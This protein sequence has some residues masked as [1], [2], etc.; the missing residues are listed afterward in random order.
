[1]PISEC[2]GGIEE[3]NHLRLVETK[4]VPA[5]PTNRVLNEIKGRYANAHNLSNEALARAYWTDV[6]DLL[7]MVED[8]KI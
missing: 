8:G 5:E 1:M 4:D 7:Q 3:V 6:A 2:A